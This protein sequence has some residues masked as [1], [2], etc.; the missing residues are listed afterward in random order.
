[1]NIFRAA[2]YN[3]SF[4]DL[5]KVRAKAYNSFGWSLAYSP[6]NTSGAQVRIEPTKMSSI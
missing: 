3:Y 5:V 6:V 4:R 1:M 2:P